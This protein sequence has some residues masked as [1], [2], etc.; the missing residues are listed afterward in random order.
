MSTSQEIKTVKI[1]DAQDWSSPIS[2]ATTFQ[3]VYTNSTYTT[4]LEEEMADLH[5]LEGPYRFYY[6]G[7][8][9]L[10]NSGTEIQFVIPIDKVPINK[11][12]NQ[13]VISFCLIAKDGTTIF[14]S[15]Q[16]NDYNLSTLK[17]WATVSSGVGGLFCVLQQYSNDEVISFDATNNS[18]VGISINGYIYW[19]QNS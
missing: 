2:F 16:T 18:I 9:F 8:G 17:L 11:F 3:H 5:I 12:V 10:T 7:A 19:Q 4:N 1:K 14:D 13:T 15:S 6:A